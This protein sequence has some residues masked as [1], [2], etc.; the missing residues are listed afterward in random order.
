MAQTPHIEKHFTASE[1]A[2]P[3]SFEPR[4]VRDYS[5]AQRKY[6]D[7]FAVSCRLDVR[8]WTMS[9]AGRACGIFAKW[10]RSSSFLGHQARCQN[11]EGT[12]RRAIPILL[13]LALSGCGGDAGDKVN[14][15]KNPET[16]EVGTNLP[17][18][19]DSEDAPREASRHSAEP[20]TTDEET[21]REALEECAD[22]L[23]SATQIEEMLEEALSLKSGRFTEED[24]R[25]R[26]GTAKKNVQKFQQ[27]Y[28]QARNRLIEIKEQKALTEQPESK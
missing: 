22:K 26:L 19:N 7:V 16:A 14:E 3:R 25:I 10:R 4:R 21:A 6:G 12:M 23:K 18:I 8:E 1:M 9:M 28:L 27:E 17:P 5:V 15:G 11:K 2:G 20:V 13:F 24:L